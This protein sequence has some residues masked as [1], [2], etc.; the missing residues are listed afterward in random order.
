MAY[1]GKTITITDEVNNTSRQMRLNKYRNYSELLQDV[2]HQFS[3]QN[4]DVFQL[5]RVRGDRMFPRY[6][7]HMFTSVLIPLE[8]MDILPDDQFLIVDLG[9]NGQPFI[10]QFSQNLTE[11]LT[12]KMT[13][14]DFKAEKHEDQY[15]R[16]Q[17]YV[18]EDYNRNG[19]LKGYYVTLG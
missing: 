7:D 4:G 10:P 9:I 2:C 13:Q 6:I 1:L 14:T 11:D 15:I 3:L 18:G 12:D 17:V 5:R 19:V 16:I 8:K